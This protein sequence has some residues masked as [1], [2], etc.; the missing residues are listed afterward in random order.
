[1]II[2][3]QPTD[4]DTQPLTNLTDTRGPI[5]TTYDCTGQ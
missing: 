3:Y 5:I 4:T 2:T 1:M